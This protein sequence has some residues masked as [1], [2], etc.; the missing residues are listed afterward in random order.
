[1]TKQEIANLRLCAQYIACSEETTPGELLSRL[2]AM[3]AQDYAGA[4]WSIGLRLPGLT[5]AGVEQAIIDKQI[6][7]TWPMRGTLHFVAAEDVRWMLKL[8][9]PRIIAGAAGRH[10]QL[11]L[12]ESVFLGSRQLLTRALEGKKQL[13]RQTLFEIL[14]RGGISTAGQR[15]IHILQRLSQEQIL[16]F[17]PHEGK[18]P[19]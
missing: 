9:T 4:L 2:G 12:D 19:T 11:E 6:V 1:M 8:L 15:G 17:R 16:C 18:Q 13:T 7:R 10:R 14:E 5:R 3:Q